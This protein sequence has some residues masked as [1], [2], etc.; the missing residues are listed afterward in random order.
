MVRPTLASVPVGYVELAAV[1]LDYAAPKLLVDQQLHGREEPLLSHLVEDPVA[2]EGVKQPQ[3]APLRVSEPP[4]SGSGVP[5]VSRRGPFALSRPPCRRPGR[6]AAASI[7]WSAR[8]PCASGDRSWP[9]GNPHC[10]LRDRRHST[11]ARASRPE[12]LGAPAV[13]DRRIDPVKHRGRDDQLEGPCS[14]GHSPEE[15]AS[16]RASCG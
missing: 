11:G 8:A 9:P 3:I 5:R 15:E 1:P 4:R 14:S 16:I 10:C 12:G 13:A 7:R 2:R 6:G